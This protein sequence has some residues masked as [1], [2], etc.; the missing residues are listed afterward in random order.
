MDEVSASPE[1]NL[2]LAVSCGDF[3]RVVNYKNSRQ[4]E[5]TDHEKH[6]LLNHHFIPSA[7]Y[8]FLSH[9]FGKQKKKH[10]QRSWL[11]KYKGLAYSKSAEGRYCKYCVLFAQTEIS[12]QRLGILVNKPFTNLKH[13]SNVLTE[14]FNRKSYLLAVQKAKAFSNVMAN[15]A[16]SIGQ[17]VNTQVAKT[18]AENRLKLRSIAATVIFCGHQAIALRGHRDDWSMIDDDSAES[19]CSGN[20][21]ALLQICIDAGDFVLKE[22]I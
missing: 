1:H 7:T 2:D 14:C 11:T 3:H 12:G 18:I 17:Q 13:A 21:H 22:H 20:F 19:S 15:K 16:V 9:T 5:L 8:K 10:F 6:Y 4:R